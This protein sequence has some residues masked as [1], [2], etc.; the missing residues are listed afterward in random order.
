MQ[1]LLRDDVSGVGK[2]GDIVDVARG[3]ARN[4]LFPTGR[5]LAATPGL[6]AQAAAMRRTR[7]LR[8]AHDR[9][10]A[11][12]VSAALSAI[13]VTI[14]A[15]A[16]AEGRLF[17]SVTTTDLAAAIEAQTGAVIDRRKI[18]LEEPIK[19]VGSHVVPVHLHSDVEVELTVEVVAAD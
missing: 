7:D 17:G 1:V 4:Y 12:S 14:S 16:G 3:F 18:E 5:A 2:R 8:D 9:E 10:S 13:T 15:R 6:Q 11:Q 19:N